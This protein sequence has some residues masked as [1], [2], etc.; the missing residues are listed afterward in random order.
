MTENIPRILIVEDE[1]ASLNLLASYFEAENYKVFKATNSEEADVILAKDTVD[2]ILLD[3]NLPG[4]DGLSLTR[5]IRSKSDVGIILV[6]HKS[7]DIDRIVGLEL[8]ADDYVSKPYNTRLLF[9]RVKNLLQRVRANPLSGPT[10]LKSTEALVFNPWTLH[11]GRRLLVNSDDDSEVQLTEG[12]YKLLITLI[13]HAGTVLSRDQIMNRM[14]RREWF[15]TDRT[16]DVMIAR[17][18]KKL[19]DDRDHPKYINTAHGTGYIFIADV[20]PA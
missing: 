6:T 10:G 8:G 20:R 7:D 3:I 18:R 1:V 5:E 4:K 15:P 2:I 9:A 11:V 19:G 16:I 12:E 13:N 14:E 17:I